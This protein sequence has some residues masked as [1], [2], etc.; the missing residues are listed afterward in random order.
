MGL[1]KNGKWVAFKCTIPLKLVT[2]ESISFIASVVRQMMEH[3]QNLIDFR[4]NTGA[5]V[6]N[7]ASMTMQLNI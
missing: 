4:V 2:C 5:E 6:I 7:Y 1:L 3:R